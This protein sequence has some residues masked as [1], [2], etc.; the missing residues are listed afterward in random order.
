MA[1]AARA[2][3]ILLVMT[4]QLAST[5]MNANVER[6]VAMVQIANDFRRPSEVW[7][8]Q[9]PICTQ[10]RLNQVADIKAHNG[11]RTPGN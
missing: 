3:T 9:A 2:M 10:L 6:A 5:R 4:A 7:I 1:V 11:S 8:I